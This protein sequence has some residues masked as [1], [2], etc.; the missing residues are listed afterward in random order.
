MY[1]GMVL[2]LDGKHKSPLGMVGITSVSVEN[3]ADQGTVSM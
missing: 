2:A 1:N 3:L